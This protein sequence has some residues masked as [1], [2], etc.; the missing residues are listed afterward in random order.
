MF[1]SPDVFNVERAIIRD[2]PLVPTLAANQLISLS[3]AT[4]CYQLPE[5]MPML[6]MNVE[7]SHI[8]L[9]L[10]HL[11][12]HH[13]AQ[14]QHNGIDWMASFCM[15]CNSGAVF[16]PLLEGRILHFTER[17]IYNAMTILADE[18]TGSI[19]NHITGECMYGPLQ[20]QKLAPL[21][22]LQHITVAQAQ[23]AYPNSLYAPSQLSVED[24]ET[25]H[26]WNAWRV[27]DA[28]EFPA[29]WLKTI[30]HE[31]TRLPHIEMGLG[32]WAGSVARFYPF[33]TLNAN[34]NV[35]IDTF[36]G[37]TLVVYVDPH[38]S[39]PNALY[40]N[41]V[42]AFWRNDTL[43]LDDDMR[44]REGIVSRNG[45]QISVQRPTQLFQRWYSF[46]I[47]FPKGDIY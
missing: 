42:N 45:E 44:I 12:F 40:I 28:P 13:V 24:E 5:D 2:K 4:L 36:N 38:T 20:G 7:Q 29:R 11:V 3:E 16:S 14:G 15:I 6:L 8:L 26:S 33:R 17:G 35:L 43:Q 22:I 46:A 9:N 41:T 1:N 32:V 25:A 10:V 47:L 27:M 37:R 31:D 21:S 19:W 18:E 30:G 23:L 39:T 34:D